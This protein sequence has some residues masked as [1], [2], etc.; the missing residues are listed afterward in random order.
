MKSSTLVLQKNASKFVNI[1]EIKNVLKSYTFPI[2]ST[3]LITL[4]SFLFVE[5]RC[6]TSQIFVIQSNKSIINK[7]I[8]SFSFNQKIHGVS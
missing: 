7:N 6:K 8:F 1:V 3:V 2:Q 5:I 4:T